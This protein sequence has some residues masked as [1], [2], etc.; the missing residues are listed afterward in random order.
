MHTKNMVHCI[1][2]F[3]YP[4]ISIKYLKSNNARAESSTQTTTETY[5][6]YRSIRARDEETVA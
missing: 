3:Q 6:I 2:R 1:S 4:S 5:G